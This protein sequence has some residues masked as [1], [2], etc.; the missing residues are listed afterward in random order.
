M[1]GIDSSQGKQ[2]HAGRCYLFDRLSNSTDGGSV[3]GEKD[4]TQQDRHH[5]KH[6]FVHAALENP[7]AN[8]HA[9]R[10]KRLIRLHISVIHNKRGRLFHE[11]HLVRVLATGTTVSLS[12]EGLAK[13][14]MIKTRQQGKKKKSRGRPKKKKKGQDNVI[15]LAG[16]IDSFSFA[17]VGQ[18]D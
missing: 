16:A 14:I 18:L 6:P 8:I 2:V 17:L 9:L 5:E 1:N 3:R 10:G 12:G 13:W 7:T 11:R 15:S 4:E